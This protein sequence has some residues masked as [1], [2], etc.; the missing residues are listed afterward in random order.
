MFFLCSGRNEGPFKI[1]FDKVSVKS[2]SYLFCQNGLSLLDELL[3]SR[4]RADLIILEWDLYR[5]FSDVIFNV[6]KSKNMKIPLILIG[7]KESDCGKLLADWISLNELKYD[8]QILESCYQVLKRISLAVELLDM[9]RN[10]QVQV[11]LK[12]KNRNTIEIF[13]I[14]NSLSPSAV[15][16]FTYLYK[17]RLREVSVAEIASFMKIQGSDAIAVRN[18]TYSYISRLRKCIE[19][20]YSCS[21]KIMRTRSG[22]YKLF[23][24]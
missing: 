18:A 24:P 22:H 9:G 6:L 19:K 12:K 1:L 13:A 7:K 3:M 2:D 8:I 20:T 17:N 11:P 21:V 5:T 4:T 14:K 23:L 10:V 15:K 16:L